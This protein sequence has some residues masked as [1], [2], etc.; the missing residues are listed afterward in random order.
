MKGQQGV[1]ETRAVTSIRKLYLGVRTR[2]GLLG[3]LSI[4]EYRLGEAFDRS[5]SLGLTGRRVVALY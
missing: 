4:M 1:V 3:C 2:C 5:I